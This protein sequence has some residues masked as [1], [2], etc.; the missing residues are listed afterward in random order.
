[1]KYKIPAI[2]W[3]LVLFTLSSVP[4][5]SVPSVG[6]SHEDIIAHLI[7]YAILG[8]LLAMA[9]VRHG[10][11]IDRQRILVAILFGIIYAFSDEF[12]QSFVPGRFPSISDFIA[13]SVGLVIGGQLFKYYPVGPEMS[14]RGSQ[15]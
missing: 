2:I 12:H 3:A 14:E 10:R 15:S 13:D 7:V 4:G 9:F 8:Y 6:F 1:M 5:S 11:P